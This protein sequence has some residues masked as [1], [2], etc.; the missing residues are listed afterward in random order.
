MTFGRIPAAL[1]ALFLLA[2][3]ADAD[4]A[5]IRPG[6]IVRGQFVQERHLQGF[7]KPLIS[8]G[9]FVLA[10]GEGLIW[11]V[12]SPFAVT[13]VVTPAGLLQQAAGTE[14]LRLPVSQVPMMSRLYQMLDA[15]L[16]GNLGVLET[17]FA[18][19]RN[20]NRLTLVPLSNGGTA[21]VP[22]RRLDLEVGQFV[23][24]VEI[25]RQEGDFD[26]IRFSDQRR[27]AGPLEP[28]EAALLQS[29]AR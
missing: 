13:T 23:E 8:E 25:H 15:A 16:S 10:P 24:T 27:S 22:F 14:S 2:G 12:Q 21:A 19:T 29:A 17:A 7:S 3:A 11:T 18:V 9:R 5:A 6:D 26:R 1:L 4:P 28:D 20:G